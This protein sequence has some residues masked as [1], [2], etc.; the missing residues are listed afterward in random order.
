MS[1]P[2]VCVIGAGL[3]GLTAVKA[4]R[5]RGVPVQAFEI[6]DRIGGNW[7]FENPNGMSSAYRS[8][9][10]DTPK[11]R[12][13]FTD[14]PMPS[15]WPDFLHHSLVHEYLSR[16]M[17]T[18]GLDRDIQLRTRVR[19]AERLGD[20]GW[21]VTVGPAR[22]GRAKKLRFD[23]LVVA[24]GHHWDPRLPDPPF[25]G[26]FEGET[27]HS[28]HYIDPYEPL[29]LRG[30]RVLVVGIG[31]SAADIASE[32][33]H[34]AIT[35]RT[36]LSTRSGAWVIPLVMF[37]QPLTDLIR[38]MPVVP[39][40]LQRR[41][42][43]GLVRLMVGDPRSYGL[44]MPDHRVLEAHPT[45]S[46]ELLWRL[47]TGDLVAK[48]DIGRLEGDRVV[49]ADDSVEP[50]DVIIYATGYKVS[51]PF[52]DESFLSAPDNRLPLFKRVFRTDLPDLAFIGLCQPVPTLFG[53]CELQSKWVASYLAGE[54][55]LPPAGEMEAL[56]EHDEQVQTRHFTARPR[57]TM[58][59]DLDVYARDLSREWN[60]GRRRAAHLGPALRAAA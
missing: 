29:D 34:R 56:I 18:F 42:A 43:H 7:A 13:A 48:P 36:F 49:F 39:L 10:I 37:G 51:F 55:R 33:S 19:Q 31:N 20:G 15:D 21:E 14:L 50:I 8:L 32:L 38:T 45:A 12:L 52:F 58:Q 35:E 11:K 54:Y 28:H 57:H 40:K 3:S 2:R 16:Y 41:V 23:A 1:T 60:N 59:A 5:D 25:P 4:L 6:S 46:N 22:G 9:H 17:E 27:L 24:N 47:R 30:Q 26:S 44:P 53:F